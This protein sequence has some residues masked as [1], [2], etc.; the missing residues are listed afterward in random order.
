MGPPLVSLFPTASWLCSKS[1]VLTLDKEL[2]QAITSLL[3]LSPLPNGFLFLETGILICS[4]NTGTNNA[5]WA[6]NSIISP[7]FLYVV[8]AKMTSRKFWHTFVLIKILATP[9]QYTWRNLWTRPA[10]KNVTCKEI[11]VSQ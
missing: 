3:I 8:I 11:W 6:N 9:F 2:E 1:S 10:F 5:N 4:T 7:L